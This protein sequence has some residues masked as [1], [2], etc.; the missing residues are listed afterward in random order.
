[1]KTVIPGISVLLIT[2]CILFSAYFG[3]WIT[4]QQYHSIFTDQQKEIS[5]LES[6]NREISLINLSSQSANKT[7]F[8]VCEDTLKKL[9]LMDQYKTAMGGR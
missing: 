4:K 5:Y 3:H 6:N 7:K 9:G 8:L 1:M 2:F